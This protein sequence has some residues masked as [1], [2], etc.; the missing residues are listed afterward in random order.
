MLLFTTLTVVVS[1]R[2]LDEAV[3]ALLILLKRYATCLD[4]RSAAS[5]GST[6]ALSHVENPT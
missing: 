4:G 2:L 3:V 6:P 1:K 5:V